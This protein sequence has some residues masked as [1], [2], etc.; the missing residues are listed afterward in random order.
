MNNK[1]YLQQA[2]QLI[3]SQLIESRDIDILDI[4]FLS[5]LN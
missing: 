2:I 4:W 5:P 1:K 3:H